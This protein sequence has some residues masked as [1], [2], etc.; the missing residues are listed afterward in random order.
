MQVHNS[1]GII[2]QQT[3]WRRKQPQCRVAESG[4]RAASFC[5]LLLALTFQGCASYENLSQLKQALVEYHDSK[6]YDRDV[7]K[8]INKAA[9]YIRQRAQSGET[10]L[11]IVLDIDETALSGWERLQKLDFGRD[12]ERFIEW[13]NAA[14]APPIQPTLELYG[15]A[16]RLGVKVFFISFRIESLAAM[17]RKNLEKAGYGTF[18]GLFCRPESD[19]STSAVPFKTAT[20][21]R[22]E[23]QGFK[24]IANIGDQES[25]LAGGHAERTFKLPNPFYLT[26]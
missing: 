17:T 25:D 15:E 26:P 6:K 2:N 10:N 11:A 12:R 18:D 5:F 4:L 19:K 8:V 14:D 13:V 20:R 22:I 1:A 9:A 21:E 24:I 16:K 23:Q 7:E 3:S